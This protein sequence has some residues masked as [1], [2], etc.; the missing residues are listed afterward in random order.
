MAPGKQQRPSR[1]RGRTPSLDGE[2]PL[3]HRGKKLAGRPRVKPL[4][5]ELR[6][7]E[8]LLLDAYVSEAFAE[9]NTLDVLDLPDRLE[10]ETVLDEVA[11]DQVGIEEVSPPAPDVRHLA[12]GEDDRRA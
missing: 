2:D 8:G 4:D 7:D 5:E 10:V 9:P 11:D 3:V 12:S 6:D 1:D